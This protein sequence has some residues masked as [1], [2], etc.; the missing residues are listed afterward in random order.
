MGGN[1][2]TGDHPAR[3]VTMRVVEAMVIA[4]LTAAVSVF[5]TTRV[6]QAEIRSLTTEMQLLRRVVQEHVTDWGHP[7]TKATVE[8]QNKRMDSLENR[9]DRVNERL[10]RPLPPP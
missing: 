4:S 9:L 1:G 3:I 5:A 2:L 7:G 6:M 10:F 8:A